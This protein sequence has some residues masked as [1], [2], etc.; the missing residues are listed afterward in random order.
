MNSKPVKKRLDGETK[1]KAL[2]RH[3]MEKVPVSQ[4]CQELNI[5]PSVFYNW[6]R[7]LFTRGASVFDTKPGPRKN[8]RSG[9]KVAMLEAKIARKDE[10]IAELLE[11]HVALK[12]TLGVN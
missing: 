3:S 11:E 6:Q 7:D 5:Q 4:I 2:Q 1:I 9:E 10:V 12:K 8:D